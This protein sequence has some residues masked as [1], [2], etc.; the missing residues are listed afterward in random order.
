MFQNILPHGS[1]ASMMYRA[2]PTHLSLYVYQTKQCHIA[3]TYQ[4][5]CT[6]LH[7]ITSLWYVSTRVP[8][9][10]MSRSSDMSVHLYQTT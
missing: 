1:T 3:L 6:R 8:D 9:Y 7:N 5:T 10:T 4:Y 2:N